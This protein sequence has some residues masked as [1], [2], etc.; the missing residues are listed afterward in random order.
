VGEEV[1]DGVNDPP[2]PP[3]GDG[4]AGLVERGVRV[5]TATVGVP[6]PPL[7]GVNDTEGEGV[8][9]KDRCEESEASGD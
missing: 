5:G 2:S 4:V 7:E 9:S 3:R 6:P 8:G 1:E